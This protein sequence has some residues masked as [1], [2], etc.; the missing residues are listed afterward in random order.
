MGQSGSGAGRRQQGT[1]HPPRQSGTGTTTEKRQ[2]SA[3]DV[4]H[5][6]EAEMARRASNRRSDEM[7]AE[8][9]ERAGLT[10]ESG[11]D[12]ESYSR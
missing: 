2:Q 5:A 8:D 6:D 7:S 10:R 12:D 4:E 3:Q 9:I 11:I 1:M